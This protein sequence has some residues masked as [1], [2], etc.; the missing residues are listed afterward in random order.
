[1]TILFVIGTGRCGSTLVHE[2][3]ARHEAFG[4]VSNIEDNLPGLNRLGRWNSVLFRSVIG[5]MTEKGRIRFAPSEG[6]RVLARE[7]SPIYANSCRDLVAGDVTPWLRDR[8]RTFFESR[9]NAQKCQIFLHKYTGWSRVG[10]FSELFPDAKFIHIVRDGRAVANSWLQMPWWG[11]YRGPENWLWGAL[12]EEA[13]NEWK[14][15]RRDFGVLAG[16]AWKLLIR[17]YDDSF[18]LLPESNQMVLRYED[19]LADPRKEFARMLSFVDLKWTAGFDAHFNRYR[20]SLTRRDAFVR[21]LS[22]DQVLGLE[23]VLRPTLIRY[24]YLSDSS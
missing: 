2:V 4:F 3:L 20:F 17:S 14:S 9:A 18:A 11:G 16:L 24:G 22:T 21:D 7:V 1:M 12:E 13:L 5:R 23:K 8:F 19:V 15:H 10:F 6:Y